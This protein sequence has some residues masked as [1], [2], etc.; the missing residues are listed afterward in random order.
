M[1]DLI[2]EIWSSL[3][4]NKLRTALTGFAVAWGIFMII[5]LLGAGNGLMNAMMDSGGRMDNSMTVYGGWTTI[6]YGG[7]ERG[8]YFGLDTQDMVNLESEEFSSIVDEVSPR[9]GTEASISYA[10]EYISNVSIEGIAPI[11]EKIY[12]VN[13]AA[14]RF[15]DRKD[16]DD[17]SKVIVLSTEDAK[18]LLGGKG[19]GT[20]IIGRNVKVGDLSYKVVGLFHKKQGSWGHKAYAPYSLI[21]ALYN[22]RKDIG[23]LLFSFKGIETLEQSAQFKNAYRKTIL[24]NHGASPEDLNA[25]YIRDRLEQN[26]QMATATR[27][28]NTALWI[29]GLLTLISGIVGVSNIMLITVKERT[30]EFGIRKALGAKPGSILM[31]IMME[32]ILITAFFGL[33]GMLGGIAMNQVM[34]AMFTDKAT[35]I[36]DQTFYIF[37]NP[38]VSIG[39]AVK[40]TLT[41]IISGALAG[42]IPARKASKVMPIEALRAD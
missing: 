18:A 39:T 2:V 42:M 35:V 22:G 31:L 6:P 28:I 33:I 19:D 12:G 41:M 17:K 5:A 20:E 14:G 21:H 8:R 24:N 16:M 32:S 9:F 1:R 13:M 23:Q 4:Q 3:R 10:S 37:K 34:D 40:A 7:Y 38:S 30:H 11:F 29:L 36:A 26:E 15:I 27:T 25:I